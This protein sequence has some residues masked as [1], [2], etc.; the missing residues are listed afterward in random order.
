M[1]SRNGKK[2]QLG[3]SLIEVIIAMFMISVLLVLY[4]AALNTVALTRKLRYENVAYHVANKQMETLR[5]TPYASL[6]GSGTFSDS[7]L[8]QIPSGSASYTIAD[9]AGYGGIKEFV[10]TV[11]WND[12]ISK[13]VVLRTLA[14]TGGIN[15]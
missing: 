13:Q 7:L 10:V 14:G 4:I 2:F 15:P 3:V 1:K 5:N 8:D 12:G 9:Y 11:S 6:P